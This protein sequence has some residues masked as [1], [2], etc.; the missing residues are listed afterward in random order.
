MP[1]ETGIRE[2]TGGNEVPDAPGSHPEGAVEL[3]TGCSLC[4]E[5]KRQPST[6]VRIVAS[7]SAMRI[8]AAV[9]AEALV[10]PCA[11]LKCPIEAPPPWLA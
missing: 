1:L 2:R 10:M 3:A 9:H 6:L 7:L 11:A 8:S 4:K 5:W